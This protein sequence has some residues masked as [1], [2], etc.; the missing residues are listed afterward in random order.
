MAFDYQEKIDSFLSREISLMAQVEERSKQLA[1]LREVI[2]G[3]KKLVLT[4]STHISDARTLKELQWKNIIEYDQAKNKQKTKMSKTI[5]E[6]VS[7]NKENIKKLYS[8]INQ[9]DY[10]I[11]QA[12]IANENIE[13][14]KHCLE[15]EVNDLRRECEANYIVIEQN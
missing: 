3:Y 5:R 11:N 1:D 12:F 8:L 4:L 15:N 7:A 2:S 13:K 10:E 6:E 9:K 14:E